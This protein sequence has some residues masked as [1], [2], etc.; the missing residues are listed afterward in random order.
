MPDKKHDQPLSQP[1][2]E[3]QHTT[4]PQEHMEGPISSSMQNIRETAEDN[5]RT[6]NK[7]KREDGEERKGA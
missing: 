6:G 1:D 2:P 4:D 5:D 7:D 3:T